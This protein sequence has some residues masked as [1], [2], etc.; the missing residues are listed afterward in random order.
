[1]SGTGLKGKG[2]L[3][4]KAEAG[5]R[6]PDVH[7]P[8]GMCR[9]FDGYRGACSVVAE[10]VRP[11]ATSATTG[12]RPRV[13]PPSVADYHAWWNYSAC[14]TR[15]TPQ[16]SL[17]RSLVHETRGPSHGGSSETTPRMLRRA[18]LDHAIQRQDRA[19]R[20][21]EGVPPEPPRPEA[22]RQQPAERPT[23]RDQEAAQRL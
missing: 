5:Y 21:R 14:R 8:C 17:S 19:T 13:Q 20:G 16:C 22:D 18:F 23:W 1:M 6:V 3:L 15:A 10:L 7:Y 9:H 11:D 2:T 12:A 4:S